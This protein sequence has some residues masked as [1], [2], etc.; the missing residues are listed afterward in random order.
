M[1]H[2]HRLDFAHP[3]HVLQVAAAVAHLKAVPLKQVEILALESMHKAFLSFPGALGKPAQH[4]CN[5]RCGHIWR[6]LKLSG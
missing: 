3:G 5:I 2:F 4:F 1:A 6:G